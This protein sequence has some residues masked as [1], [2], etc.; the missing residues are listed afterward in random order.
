MPRCY[1]LTTPKPNADKRK[2]AETIYLFATANRNRRCNERGACGIDPG[3]GPVR[4]RMVTLL[5][6]SMGNCMFCVR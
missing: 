6:S 5:A 3:S 2:L 1:P 4:L